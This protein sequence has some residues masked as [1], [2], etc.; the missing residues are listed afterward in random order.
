MAR[1]I[2]ICIETTQMLGSQ[3]DVII[4]VDD[5]CSPNDIEEIARD[6]FHEYCNYGWVELN[7]GE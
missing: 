6:T 7:D 2:S 1:R 3:K 4:E 5:D